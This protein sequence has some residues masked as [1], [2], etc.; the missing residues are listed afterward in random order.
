MYQ[1]ISTVFFSTKTKLKGPDNDHL[2]DFL[3]VNAI[4]NLQHYSGYILNGVTNKA[5]ENRFTW[6]SQYLCHYK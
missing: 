3:I 1:L 6:A 4:I 2:C 5:K